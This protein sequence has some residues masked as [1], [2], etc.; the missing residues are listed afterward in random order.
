MDM[1][2]FA[3]DSLKQ[4]LGDSVLHQHSLTGG[5]QPLGSPLERGNGILSFRGVSKQQMMA[6]LQGF[7]SLELAET[8]GN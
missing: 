6:E 4:G 7:L 1:R 8:N 5:S 3:W 2:H